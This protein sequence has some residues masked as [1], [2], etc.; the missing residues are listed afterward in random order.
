MQGTTDGRILSHGDVVWWSK[1][2]PGTSW[3]Y[4]E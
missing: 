4:R 2:F 3:V 1:L